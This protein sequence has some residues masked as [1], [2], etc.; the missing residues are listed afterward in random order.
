MTAD[1][2]CAIIALTVHFIM[3][4]RRHR[5]TRAAFAE[6]VGGFIDATRRGRL[7][8][9][10]EPAATREIIATALHCANAVRRL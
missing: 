7:A 1:D 3:F 2:R 4:P 8:D 10:F 5:R 9:R 6:L